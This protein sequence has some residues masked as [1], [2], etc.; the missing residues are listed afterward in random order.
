MLRALTLV[1]IG[2]LAFAGPSK[3]LPDMENPRSAGTP[4]KIVFTPF[5]CNQCTA[6]TPGFEEPRGKVTLLRVAPEKL[7]EKLDLDDGWIVIQT[8]N[9]RILSTLRKSKVK[10]K[11]GRFARYDLVRLQSIFP[12][13]K[14]GRDGASLTAHQRAHLYHI[15]VERLYSHYSTLLDNAKPWLGMLARYELFLFDDYAEHHV[16]ADKFIGRANDKAG[17]QDHRRDN[18]N[19]MIFTTAESQVSAND[20]KGDQFFSAHVV[21]NV[22]HLLADGTHNY[23][24]ETW[25]WLEEGLAHYYER[26]ANPKRNTF[27]WTEGKKPDDLLKSNWQAVVYNQVRRGK[28]TSL[29]EWCE[30][31]QPG[32]LTAVEHGLCWSIVEWL[33]ETEPVRLAKLMTRIDDTKGKP[34]ASE[35]IQFAFGVSPSVLH[36]R[37]RAWVLAK[38]K[39]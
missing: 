35:S 38:G 16:I 39:K 7:A 17:V 22:A 1:C 27:C 28:D 23:Y 26:M 11:D 19:F 12:K 20:G 9:F 15:R 6:E 37:W 2:A 31:L 21:H 32:E 10:K 8:R 5:W 14:I 3:D 33:I 30:K 25:A 36:T 18:P 4:L 29:S 34:T 24:R 13:L